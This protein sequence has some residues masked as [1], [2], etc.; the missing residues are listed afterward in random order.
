MKIYNSHSHFGVEIEREKM[1]LKYIFDKSYIGWLYELPSLSREDIQAY[2]DKVMT[3]RAFTQL[4]NALENLYGKGLKLDVDTW[5]I[6]DERIRKAY[7]EPGYEDHVLRDICGYDEILLDDWIDIRSD[8][9]NGVECRVA[10]RCDFMFYGYSRQGLESCEANA[11]DFFDYVPENID[12]YVIK[13]R[14][15]VKESLGMGKCTAIKVCMAYFRDLAFGN[16]TRDEANLVYKDANNP[17][18]IRCFQDYVMDKLCQI[19]GEFD[20]PVQFH[21]GLGQVYGTS[22]VNLMPLMKK[23]ENVRF[24]LLHGSFPW[25]E[26]LV[27]VLYDCPNTWL[28][29]CWMH[30]LSGRIAKDT[31]INVLELIGT[32]RIMWG[33]DS[34]TIEESYGALLGG[35]NLIDEVNGYFVGKGVFD[36]EFGEQLK[37]KV[38]CKT[39]VEFF[40]KY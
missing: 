5:N 23:H 33:C 37:E 14:H 25:T 9:S 22:A 17:E 30:S 36:K 11:F 19:A 39:A 31:L 32:D 28:D 29:I 21:T 12:D 38:F 40:D 34:A 4:K 24:S 27:A 3:M 10:L 18:Y 2:F 1:S 26:D 13:M 7:E 20:I 15:Y 8:G 6:F 16:V 35:L